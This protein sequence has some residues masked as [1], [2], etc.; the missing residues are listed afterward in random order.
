MRAA[1]LCLI[2]LAACS[3]YDDLALLEVDRIEPSVIEPGSTLR[4]R[5]GGFPLGRS[6]RIVLR[7]AL[8]R[9]GAPRTTV[10]ASLA[11]HVRSDSLI[12][13]PIDAAHFEAFQGR[14]TID[15][16]L[17]LSFDSADGRREIFAEEPLT[18]D[19]LPDTAAELRVDAS[20]DSADIEAHA[21]GFGVALSREDLGVPGVR[22]LAVSP[23]SPAAKQGV[24]P[25]DTI[26]GVDGIR[27][28]RW[29]DFVPD[30]TKTESTVLITRDRLRGV[31]ALRW[32]HDATQRSVVPL[33]LA[34]FLLVGV[35]IGWF[36][37]AVLFL[38]RDQSMPALSA[39]AV[40]ASLITACAVLVVCLPALQWTT[41][42]ILILG[43]A[44]A[45]FALAT[46]DPAGASSF[47]LVIGATLAVMMLPQTAAVAEIV[48]AQRPDVLR[49]YAFQTPASSLACLAY[50]HALGT[51][52]ARWRVSASLFAA[53]AAV[54][55]ATLFLGGWPLGGAVPA[56]AIV[57]A[58]ATGLTA[59]AHLLVIPR[60]AAIG[61]CIA[62]LATSAI[63][64]F[65]DL[66][67][68]FPQW[69]GLAIGAACAVGVR[70]LVPPLRRSGAPMPA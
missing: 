22:V 39:I 10:S 35:V 20:P 14:A 2:C 47:A 57:A 44:A 52:S 48:A 63:G 23:G 50:L 55:G 12:E 4:I 65:I 36:S 29:R 16:E 24:R 49:W 59:A 41:V 30:P 33:A 18:V 69:S 58:K 5:G 70:A 9:P 62:A 28:Y 51:V 56:V 43:T 1:V 42:W 21:E 3:G 25:D 7:G 34:V 6:P 15:G 68:L 26:V 46:R 54:L 64:L 66:G 32:P 40:R 27:V 13:V 37:P 31:H 67:V 38:R 45:L 11:G 53:P 8:F 61:L 17:R 19:F 60:G